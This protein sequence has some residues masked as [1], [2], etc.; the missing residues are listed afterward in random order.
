MYWLGWLLLFLVLW[1][2]FIEGLFPASETC[3]QI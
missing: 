2:C 1:D 3:D